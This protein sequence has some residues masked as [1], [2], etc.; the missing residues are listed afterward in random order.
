MNLADV[1]ST[2]LLV[3]GI[4]NVG[5][6]DDGLGPLLIERLEADGLPPGVSVESGYQLNPE[7]ALALAAHDTVL[8]VDANAAAGAPAPYR[9]QPVTPSTELSFS[10]HAMSM[11]ALL[12]LCTRMYGRAPRAYVLAIAACRFD[13]NAPLSPPA[14]VHLEEALRD[15][16]GA[17]RALGV[18]GH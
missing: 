6:Q 15:V 4:G 7:D 14:A 9:L 2:P 12:A 13:V 17:L 8:F 11:G 10:T 1:L 3:Y 5:R 18:T 16:R